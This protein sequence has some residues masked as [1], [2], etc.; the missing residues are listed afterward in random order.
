MLGQTNPANAN[1]PMVR[2]TFRAALL[3]FP[4]ALASGFFLLVRNTPPPPIPVTIDKPQAI[5]LA[6]DYAIRLG[7]PAQGWKASVGF[8]TENN[9]LD[10]VNARPARQK[11]WGAAPPVYANITLRDPSGDQS[12]K[13]PVSVNG[14]VLG[15]SWKNAPAGDKDVSDDDARAI[16]AVFAP[17]GFAFGASALE[18]TGGK[19][20]RTVTSHSSSVPDIDLKLT[21]KL[22]GNRVVGAEVSAEEHE[23]AKSNAG[24]AIQT[25]LSTTGAC[26]LCL[27]ALFSIF[28]YVGRTLQQE[29]SHSRSLVVTLLCAFFFVLLGFNAV[30]N[31]GGQDL[32]L[33][34]LVTVFF[35]L[36][37]LGGAILGAAY[38]SG[39]GDIREAW[40]GKLTSLD[41]LLGG[42]LFSRNIGVS[43][44]A[45]GVFAAWM[46]LALGLAGLPFRDAA[47][48]GSTSMSGP[49]VNLGW[50]I[51]IVSS[52]LIALS[53]G[54]AALL[55]PLA[56]LQRYL[57]RAK[58]WHLPVLALCGIVLAALRMHS[59]SNAEFVI[60]SVVYTAAL[61]I[62]F[63]V[64]DLLASLT[65]VTVLVAVA[66]VALTVRVAP[67]FSTASL[68]SHSIALVAG[69]TYSLICLKWGTERTEQEVRPLYAKHIEERKSLEAEVSAA[70]EAQLRLLPESVP[71]FAGLNISAACVPAEIVGGD[72]YDFFLLGDGRLGIFI[73]EGNNRGLAAALTIALAK[74]YLMHA[75]ERYFEPVE[76]LS[77][78]E[79]ALGAFLDT[80]L[81]S[82]IADCAFAA[83]DVQGGEV[84]YAR[85][86]AYP[87]VLVASTTGAS[88][89]ERMVPVKGRSKPI[90]EGRAS[91]AP[92]DHVLLFTDGLG[93]RLSGG[94]RDPEAVACALAAQEPGDADRLRERLFAHSRGVTEPDDL[95]AVVIRA[96]DVV[97][98]EKG[99][100]ESVA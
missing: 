55:Q 5:V 21:V 57:K 94:H 13:I 30:V 22:K 15:F 9:L 62:P 49:F 27:V 72:F 60:S 76:I 23:G 1:S 31:S 11:I 35:I 100:L 10:F 7:I 12:V 6:R 42:F 28:R 17:A 68:V 18:K 47:P 36:G 70:R 29:V 51:S 20:D 91:F 69:F 77:R 54:A 99:A 14:K 43:L 65:C 85:T 71:Q 95:T 73:A 75:A 79:M 61:L 48:E 3:L 38:G 58:R 37:L 80:G 97:R 59:R 46:A 32:P 74:G 78:M 87:R 44:L 84:R 88:A 98:N 83:I 96:L 56:F 64:V 26:F 39:E 86:G 45:G 63:Y 41:A 19:Q 33:A 66:S 92:G 50:I 16:A 53:F 25:A 67:A 24:T 52:P 8:N 89:T 34:L 81:G 93:R 2:R 82:E 90:A 40:P 4:F